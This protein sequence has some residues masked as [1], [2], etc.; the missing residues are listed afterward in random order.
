MYSSYIAPRQ[1]N[2]GTALTLDESN[3]ILVYV[4]LFILPA[5]RMMKLE[6]SNDGKEET[7]A[8]IQNEDTSV[9]RRVHTPNL[10]SASS[11]FFVPLVLCMFSLIVGLSIDRLFVHDGGDALFDKSDKEP[12]LIEEREEEEAPTQNVLLTGHLCGIRKNCTVT[13]ATSN[14]IGAFTSCT[15]R[16][17]GLDDVKVMINDIPPNVTSSW[18]YPHYIKIHGVESLFNDKASTNSTTRWVVWLDSD[19]RVIELRYPMKELIA[20]AEAQSTHVIV[21]ATRNNYG[22]FINNMFLVRNSVWGRKFIAV[23]KLLSLEGPSCGN[24]DQCHFGVAM[25]Q[26]VLDFLRQDVSEPVASALLKMAWESGHNVESELLQDGLDTVACG[27]P[28][29]DGDGSRFRKVGPILLVPSWNFT[30]SSVLV[31]TSLT[32]EPTQGFERLA[33]DINNASWPMGL[34]AKYSRLF[35]ESR[36]EKLGGDVHRQFDARFKPQLDKFC[37]KDELQMIREGDICWAK[38]TPY[39]S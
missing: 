7:A 24:F 36:K 2:G 38:Y 16:A 29:R 19:V 6:A 26:L 30:D 12:S 28:C 17:L 31:N 13:N 11:R 34:H 9:G 8:F 35:C 33:A 15:A 39:P 32:I 3:C 10:T 37:T 5:T 14:A 23:W 1:S 20:Y 27:G 18:P 22:N 25:I 4:A 21:A